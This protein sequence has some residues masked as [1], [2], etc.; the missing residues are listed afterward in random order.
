M[1]GDC[2]TEHKI[3]CARASLLVMD[4]DVRDSTQL[5]VA[6]LESRLSNL[7]V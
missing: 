2:I 4:A 5:L 6:N 7:A 1:N 3:G